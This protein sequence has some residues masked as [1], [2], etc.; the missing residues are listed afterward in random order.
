MLSRAKR[1]WLLWSLGANYALY[2]IQSALLITQLSGIDAS[3]VT[4]KPIG[5]M[6]IAPALYLYFSLLIRPDSKMHKTDAW[7][8]LPVALFQTILITGGSLADILD[9]AFIV[10]YAAYLVLIAVT[11]RKHKSLLSYLGDDSQVAVRYL[12]GFTI[13]LSINLI[14]EVSLLIELDRGVPL[15]D[16]LS[17]KIGAALFLL[18]HITMLLLALQRSPYLEWLYNRE[19][20]TKPVGRTPTLATAQAEQIFHQWNALVESERLFQLEFGITLSQAA[21]KMQIPVRQLSNAV[22]Q[23]Y[24]NTFSVHLNDRRIAHAKELLVREPQLPIIDVM[25]QSGFSSKSNFNKEFARVA[26]TT[27]SKYR[28]QILEIQTP[29]NMS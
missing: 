4:L 5:A 1:Q 22:N 12:G 27:P 8:L 14:I 6:L 17:L 3:I 11:L 28:D 21:K 15:A 20:Q 26:A 23:I 19:E 25:L 16:S 9:F 18:V 13:L 24:G 2:T 10:T 29:I 7:H